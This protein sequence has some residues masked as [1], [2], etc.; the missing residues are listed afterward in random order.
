MRK[1]SQSLGKRGKGKSRKY[2]EGK[3]GELCEKSQDFG[4]RIGLA[5]GTNIYLVFYLKIYLSMNTNYSTT[6]FNIRL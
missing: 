1:I 6:K 4:E 5:C 3:F 2:G